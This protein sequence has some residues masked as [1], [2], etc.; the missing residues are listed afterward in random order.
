M[1]L[2]IEKNQSVNL[3][4]L[5]TTNHTLGGFSFYN[6]FLV[7]GLYN[8]LTITFQPTTYIIYPDYITSFSK[9]IVQ[10]MPIV[11]EMF[12]TSNV[13]KYNDLD[14]LSISILISSSAK[15]NEVVYS[16]LV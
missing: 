5:E 7:P 8:R 3:A 13:T 6:L 1:F 12:Q 4:T 16:N 10:T 9:R 2:F 15:V 14:L 11:D